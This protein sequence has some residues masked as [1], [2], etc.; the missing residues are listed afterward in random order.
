M[1]RRREKEGREGRRRK[2]EKRRERREM[3][4]ERGREEGGEGEGEGGSDTVAIVEG[5]VAVVER[6]SSPSSGSLSPSPPS[7][8]TSSLPP[9]PL[10]SSLL[11]SALA[12]DTSDTSP[13]S[14]LADSTRA[15][16]ALAQASMKEAQ[17]S[18]K[19]SINSLVLDVA[20]AVC[21]PSHINAHVQAAALA[22][23]GPAASG[24][25]N[26][27][28][29]SCS[30][31]PGDRNGQER[32]VIV[33]LGAVEPL[34]AS[35][36]GSKGE[37]LATRAA[38]A[39]GNIAVDKRGRE[40]VGRSH[41]V[42][43]LVKV[44]SKAAH[45]DALA[46]ALA[47]AGT[48]PLA[49]HAAACL[50]NLA[51]SS[52]LASKMATLGAIPPLIQ[53][54]RTGSPDTRAVC[55]CCLACIAEDSR[56]A[57]MVCD[58]GGCGPLVKMLGMEE[59]V[60]QIAAAGCLTSLAR[61]GRNKE[62]IKRAGGVEALVK[63]LIEEEK[64][65]G[66][67]AE[68]VKEKAVAVLLSVCEDERQRSHCVKSGMVPCALRQVTSGSPEGRRSAVWILVHLADLLSPEERMASCDPVG[69][70]LEEG[71]W[72]SR[73][74]AAGA[75]ARIYRTDE[76]KMEF[77]DRGDGLRR[78]LE[79]TGVGDPR[80]HENTLAAVL[81]LM[82]NPEVPDMVLAIPGAISKIA[83]LIPALNIPVRKLALGILKCLSLYDLPLVLS[84]VPLIY[85]HHLEHPPEELSEYMAMFVE[86]RKE[87]GYLS[88]IGKMAEKLTEAE[89]SE[90]QALFAELDGDAS[91]S[92]DAGEI[93]L[94]IQAMTG[95]T[96]GKDRLQ[97]L[98]D[99]VDKD[100]SGVIEWDEFLVVMDAIKNGKSAGLG[101]ILGNAL[102]A[103][104]KRSAMG[105]GLQKMGDM[106]NRKKLEAEEMMN[107]ELKEQRDEEERKR[108]TEKYWE[109]E[110]IKRERMR[111]E[112]KMA[113]AMRNG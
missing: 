22:A 100:G 67:L 52:S 29:G 112:A 3:R 61:G 25:S 62:R 109:G 9:L 73:A 85:H 101:S 65:G 66:E 48:S 53:L 1:G 4:K 69:R 68:M 78:L 60:C 24:I 82:E 15:D 42:E 110:K 76:E 72:G 102:A 55:A 63:V 59:R 41:A 16:F 113:N 64:G 71:G 105:K 6:P 8:P 93:G 35:L 90:Y 95:E 86:K 54:L 74:A 81:A 88:R 28:R 2:E 40:A 21:Q 50:R 70:M 49:A 20:L 87:K 97:K 84:Q 30:S 92:I 56:R 75:C 38:E 10:S 103:G 7:S 37:V 33:S 80:I 43:N 57:E 14:A 98:V 108:V 77:V 107:G 36:D 12:D 5:S 18:M 111:E 34:A 106:W 99:D 27:A 17:A 79:M 11:S 26:Y 32:S 94:L 44:L 91:G 47:S 45:P 83:R 46:S 104:F 51:L 23:A 58:Y 19:A 39:L 13:D 89:L 31:K 96:L